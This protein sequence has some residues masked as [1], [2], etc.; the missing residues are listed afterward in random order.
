MRTISKENESKFIWFDWMGCPVV[1][2]IVK[3][4]V[5]RSEFQF[6]DELLVLHEVETVEHIEPSILRE[7][8]SV[9]DDVDD[10]TTSR[11]V[12]EAVCG[13]E[14]LIALVSEDRR[15]QA[16]KRRQSSDLVSGWVL[17]D[18]C[19]D[20][21]R[22]RE[23]PVCDLFLGEHGRDGELR[24]TC[25]EDP[26]DIFDVLALHRTDARS[27]SLRRESVELHCTRN[28]HAPV[29][30]TEPDVDEFLR[31]IDVIFRVCFLPAT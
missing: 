13:T 29:E 3:R 1:E 8:Q 20:D 19:A 31:R 24:E 6:F 12:V 25:P 28:C 17:D 26:V 9:F 7:N 11:D 30:R 21:S 2:V 18:V 5:S 4:S 22:P 15:W 14:E 16:V 27:R 23:E 10:G